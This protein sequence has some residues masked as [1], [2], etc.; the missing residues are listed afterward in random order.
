MPAAASKESQAT[1]CARTALRYLRANGSR[2]CANTAFRVAD[3][4]SRIL[5]KSWSSDHNLTPGTW[6]CRR[7]RSEAEEPE[8]VGQLCW[9]RFRESWAGS[10]ISCCGSAAGADAAKRRSRKTWA[11]FA[12]TVFAEVGQEPDL[13][14]HHAAPHPAHGCAGADVA[15]R[16][17]RK[18]WASSAGTV[19]E[20]VGQDAQ[21]FSTGWRPGSESNRR[22]R[23]CRPLHDH[24]A[25]RPVTAHS[26]AR[27][28]VRPA[29]ATRGCRTGCFENAKP[30]RTGVSTRTGAGNETRTRDPDLGKVVL[31]QL[32][33][34]RKRPRILRSGARMSTLREKGSVIRGQGSE[35]SAR[36]R[37]ALQLLLGPETE[38]CALRITPPA[39]PARRRAGRRPPTTESGRP[40]SPAG[41]RRS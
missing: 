6:M 16:R 5:S 19:F 13:P 2:K 10:P 39:S 11:S 23:L 1:G 7:R 30:R 36:A 38:P 26:S 29:R 20:K 40:R 25:T 28:V 14:E 4:R 24:S 15:K 22:T 41:P 12:G 37:F 31:Y 27:A 17:R 18:T 3:R 34:S 9:H 21:S 32:S 8:D 33:Y 35:R